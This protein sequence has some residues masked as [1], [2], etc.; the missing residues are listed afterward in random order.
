MGSNCFQR[1][2][3]FQVELRTDAIRDRHCAAV[4]ILAHKKLNKKQIFEYCCSLILKWPSFECT[5]DHSIQH[6]RV[7]LTP[8]YNVI[9]GQVSSSDFIHSLL[10]QVING[11]ARKP[12]IFSSVG[13]S[14]LIV[15][16]SHPELVPPPISLKRDLFDFL[17]CGVT[18][19]QSLFPL[20]LKP[21]EDLPPCCVCYTL[22]KHLE[23]G[24]RY[25]N[26]DSYHCRP[27]GKV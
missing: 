3:L 10:V 14:T 4:F 9:Q 2:V 21:T 27:I 23:T 20:C 18:P 25:S 5:E 22:Y 7:G 11:T 15:V 13:Y 26:T 1:G 24:K 8:H 6:S 12:E 17:S 19:Q 16:L